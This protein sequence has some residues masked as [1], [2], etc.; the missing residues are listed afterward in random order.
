M[1]RDFWIT[2][3]IRCRPPNNN[4]SGF[5]YE[6]EAIERCRHFL[7]E[8]IKEKKPKVIVAIGGIA[9]AALAGEFRNWK[10]K[11]VGIDELRGFVFDGPEGIPVIGT[12]HPSYLVRGNFHLARVSQLDILRAVEV[13]RQGRPSRQAHYN[14]HPGGV[15]A[16][17]FVTAY[18]EAL[19]AD[20]NLPLAFD[21]ETP[22]GTKAEKDDDPYDFSIEDDASYT[23]LRISFAFREDEAITFPW[24]EPF[25]SIAKRLL[26]S[27]GPKISFNGIAYDIPRLEAAGIPV[28]G[29]QIDGMHLWKCYE[30]AFPMSLRFVV[31][32]LL[33]DADQWKLKVRENEELY[34]CKDSDYLLRAYNKIKAK[35]EEAGRWEMFQR[36]FVKCGTVLKRMT[37]R[38][39]KVDT[40]KRAAAREEIEG[41]LIKQVA[42]IQPLVPLSLRPKKIFKLGL[43]TLKKKGYKREDF[44][45]VRDQLPELPKG[46]VL[47][48]EGLIVS[49]PKPP[50]SPKPAKPV[51][52]KKRKPASSESSTKLDYKIQD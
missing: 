47:N 31:S 38:G 40:E 7:L 19:A 22:Y 12:Y 49:A 42:E 46:K 37:R 27:A 41:W 36:H 2:N 35:L 32:L 48:E 3:T 44:V 14:L 30:P 5:W 11:K 18:E 1:D 13:A 4:L 39:I 51:V 23:V 24:I 8:V 21:I 34:N 9:H 26:A 29:D 10:G 28:A 45:L 15:Q 33:P 6:K 43:E 20:P 50:K 52:K 25:V 17:A 16:H